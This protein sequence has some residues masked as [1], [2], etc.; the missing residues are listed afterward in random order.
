MNLCTSPTGLLRSVCD[1]V[2]LQRKTRFKRCGD[3]I[4]LHEVSQ[5]NLPIRKYL[6][7]TE[8]QE[9]AGARI[10]Y[11]DELLEDFVGQTASVDAVE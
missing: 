9:T 3:A 5:N 4:Q 6:H 2:L 8:T 11:R 7:C 1:I 10:W